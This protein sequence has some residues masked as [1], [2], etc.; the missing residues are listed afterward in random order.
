MDTAIPQAQLQ[1]GASR[2]AFFG[3]GFM[4]SFPAM[5]YGERVV[6]KCRNLDRVAEFYIDS[7]HGR[8]RGKYEYG[9]Y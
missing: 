2:P 7:N 6:I 3:F 9:E 4:A 5:G 1:G 8:V